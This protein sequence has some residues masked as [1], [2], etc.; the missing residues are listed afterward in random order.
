MANLVG[1]PGLADQLGQ[2]CTR[3]GRLFRAITGTFHLGQTALDGIVFLDQSAADDFR[4]VRRQ[5]Q[6]DTHRRELLDDLLRT[7]ATLANARDQ[8]AEVRLAAGTIILDALEAATVVLLGD[9]GKIQKLVERPGDG[10]QITIRQITQI[11][12]QLMTGGLIALLA[13]FGQGADALDACDEV[14]AEVGR[15]G[16]AE[17]VTENTHVIAQRFMQVV[18]HETL[19]GSDGAAA[20]IFPC[21]Q[22]HTVR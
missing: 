16:L 14:I 10:Q 8:L 4:R 12:D 6:L 18:T 13:L 2:A 9:V 15:D 3:E 19:L 22:G 7:E 5:Y 20:V 17:V 11:V 21:H 1:V